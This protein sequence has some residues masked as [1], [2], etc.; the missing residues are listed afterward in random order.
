M[1]S[2]VLKGKISEVISYLLIEIYLSERIKDMVDNEVVDSSK[3][4]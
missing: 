1:K 4:H 3:G 2:F